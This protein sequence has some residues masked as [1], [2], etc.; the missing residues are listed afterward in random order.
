M[1][2][3]RTGPNT[4]SGT[5]KAQGDAYPSFQGRHRLKLFDYPAY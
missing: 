2:C 5:I 3:D 1:T 4:F